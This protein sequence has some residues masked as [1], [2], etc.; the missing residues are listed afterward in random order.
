MPS[1]SYI[2]A[3]SWPDNVIG[4]DN[5]LPWHLRTDLQRFKQITFGHVIIMG[6]KTLSSIG[7]ALPGRINVVLSRKPE[8]DLRND[9]W[10]L[11]D[12][13]LLWTAT[14][15]DAL[16]VADILSI[17][18]D[19]KHVFVIGGADMFQIFSDLVNRVYI[20]EVFMTKK[21]QGDLRTFEFSFDHRKWKTLEEREIPAGP[22]DEYPSR[23]SVLERRTK[24]VRYIDLKDYMAEHEAARAWTAYQLQLLRNSPRQTSRTAAFQHHFKISRE[25]AELEN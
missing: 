12:T 18:R 1:I 2:V 3:R 17:S 24:T 7:R 9:F 20:T 13:M 23:F 11:S 16:F 25:A 22:R 10:Q 4:C 19:K 8:S 5:E 15:E 14:R 6:R 21:C